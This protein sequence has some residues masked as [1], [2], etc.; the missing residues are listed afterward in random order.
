MTNHNEVKLPPQNLDAER[1]V[2]GSLMMMPSAVDEIAGIIGADSFYRDA[3]GKMFQAIVDMW[4]RGCRGIDPVTL[5]EDLVRRGQLAE[6]GGAAYIFEI[7]ESV[8]HAA[9]GTY[10]AKIVL[11]KSRLRAL[12]Y[13]CHDTLQQ[14]YDATGDGADDLIVEMDQR[15]LRLRDSGSTGELSSMADAVDELEAYESNPAAV[16]RT[17]LPELDWMLDGGFREA[18]SVIVAGRPGHGKSAL[19]CQFARTFAERGEPA[20]VISLEMLQR[21]IA[22]RF[23]K[24]IGRDQLRRLPI[25]F[26]DSAVQANKIC[27]RIRYASRRHGIKI[28]V[29]DYMQL[30]EP[31]DKK[32]QRERQVAEV[33]RSMKLLAKELRIPIVIACQLNRQSANEKRKPRLSDLRES[34]SIEQDADIVLMLHESEDGESEIVVAKHRGGRCGLIPVVFDK[35]NFRF[36]DKPQ[37]WTGRL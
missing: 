35:P 18:Q 19:A 20:L 31:D 3:H 25:Y 27:S 2:L 26:D 17:G 36:T 32:S 24:T 33:S 10:Y 7:V 14:A 4:R 8:P 13:L 9:H 16:G 22:G 37:V 28:A 21:E 6:V 5:A 34:G 23:V 1:G 29:L 15:I 12:I 30:V 11:E